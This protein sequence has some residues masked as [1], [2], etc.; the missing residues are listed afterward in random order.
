MMVQA[1]NAVIED[2]VVLEGGSG[3]KQAVFESRLSQLSSEAITLTYETR[4]GMAIAGS[5]YTSAARKVT[6]AAGQTLAS[7]TADV[8]RDTSI[9]GTEKSS[10][11][12]AP[13]PADADQL[14]VDLLAA[15]QR[16]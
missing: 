1:K 5:E 11:V 13:I 9:K 12:V 8:T 15:L 6:F 7:V 14:A 4:D 10:L 2:V 16:Y 3:M